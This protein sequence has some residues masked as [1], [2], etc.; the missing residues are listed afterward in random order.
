NRGRGLEALRQAAGQGAQLVCYAE[1]AFTPFYPQQPA[2]GGVAKLAETVPGPTTEAFASLAAEL[3]VAVV[4]NLFERDGDRTYDCSP[5]IDA[6]GRLLGKTRMVHVP[7]YPCFHEKGYYGLGD[8][9]VPVVDTAA[10]RIGVAICYDRH[11]PEIMRALALAGAE[12]V[13]IPQAGAID[14]WPDGLFEAE[15]RVASFHNGFFTALCNRVGREAQ[16]EFAGESFVC[17]PEGRVIARAG[18][19]TEEVLLCD[20]DLSLVSRSHARRLFIPDR[21]PELYSAWFT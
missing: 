6:E 19:G 16:L 9:G 15:M 7:D 21:R 20:A 4:L 5:V 12:V 17:D 10:G 18:K 11:Y 2:T 8:L 3:G 1:L 14:E 13:V